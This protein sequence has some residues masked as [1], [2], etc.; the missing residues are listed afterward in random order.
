M[1]QSSRRCGER[2]YPLARPWDDPVRRRLVAGATGAGAGPHLVALQRIA[3]QNAGNRASPGP[4]YEA[5]V[6]YVVA[7][8]RAAGYDVSTPTYPLP[9]RRRRDGATCGRN[10]VAQ[11]RTGDPGR[12]VVVGAHLDSVRKG[13]GINDN[14]S[15]VAALLEIATRLGGSP[16]I[17]NAVRFAF[18][19]S[20]EDDLEGSTHYVKTLSRGDRDD[21]LLY[22]NLDM[23]ASSNAGY[24]VLGGE[25]KTRAEFGPR[26][27]AQVACVLV[28]QLAATGVVARTTPFDRESD[29]AAFIDAGIPSGGV[30]SG[31]RKNKSKK[32]ARRWGGQAGEPFDP[33]Y[34]TRRDRLDELHRTALD[35]FTRAVAG[36]VAHFAVSIDTRPG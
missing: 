15:G 35:R 2:E 9:K 1:V 29:Y 24:F 17:R 30:W 5:S 10:V 20:E 14:G 31:D 16:P 28:E 27:S 11:T 12:V 3:D 36:A 6:Q 4:G 23:I 8:L 26:G 7:V 21:I 13:P 22:L 19:G 34:H 18:W 32:Q 33:R 25:G